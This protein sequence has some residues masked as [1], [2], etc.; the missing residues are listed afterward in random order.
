MSEEIIYI[1]CEICHKDRPEENISTYQYIVP[2]TTYGGYRY[3]KHCNDNQ[4]CVEATWE[5]ADSGQAL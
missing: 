1:K 3:L 5:K 2:G 4:E